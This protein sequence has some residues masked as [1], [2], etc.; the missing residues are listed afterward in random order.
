MSGFKSFVAE[1]A[2]TKGSGCWFAV[3]HEMYDSVVER[4][5]DCLAEWVDMHTPS[6]IVEKPRFAIYYGPAASIEQTRPNLNRRAFMWG[7]DIA[8]ELGAET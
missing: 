3:R 6:P 1:R 2:G 4:L 5:A 8:R 7:R